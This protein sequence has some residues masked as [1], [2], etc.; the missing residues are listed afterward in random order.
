MATN[1]TVGAPHVEERHAAKAG[2]WRV[3]EDVGPAGVFVL[4]FLFA[5]L[6]LAALYTIWA[7][8]PSEA[9]TG[10]VVA[11]VKTV[12][13][14]WTERTVAR[15]SLF[16][17]TVAVAGGLGGIVHV[18]R[19]LTW[20]T[21]NRLLKWSWVPFYLLRPVLGAAMAS[22]LYF[23]VRAGLFS[24]SASTAEASPYGFAALAALAGLFSDQAAEKLKKVAVE[25]FDEAP[26]GKDAV[27]AEPE[28]EVGVPTERR[29]TDAVLVGTVNP[30][31]RETSFRFEW[32]ESTAYGNW[33]PHDVE[34]I[35]S[36][37]AP[38]PV[39]ARIAGLD[40][41]KAYHYRLVAFSESGATASA[42]H[43]LPAFHEPS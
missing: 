2:V 38:R 9:K 24:P 28:A 3:G 27:T 41:K 22:L 43:V 12:H 18:L 7:F 25:L 19:S 6:A 15:E 11:R 40:P 20:Y 36:G 39:S 8:W 37:L 21:G 33:A 29:Q 13:F 1:A 30:R 34:K 10:S 14:F 31:G 23:I 35:G 4:L 5:A 16:F 26:Q 42:D 32:G 17:V